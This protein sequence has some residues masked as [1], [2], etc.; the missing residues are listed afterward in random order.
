MKR[1]LAIKTGVARGKWYYTIYRIKNNQLVELGHIYI[2]PASTRGAEYEVGSFLAEHGYV[3]KKYRHG[4]NHFYGSKY[5]LQIIS[6][7]YV[8]EARG[9]KNAEYYYG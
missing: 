9:K 7:S 4:Y 2:Q 6:P 5:S 8:L 3:P 1:F